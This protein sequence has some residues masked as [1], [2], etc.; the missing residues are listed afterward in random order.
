MLKKM[1]RWFSSALCVYRD[2]L[3][4]LWLVERYLLELVMTRIIPT[5]VQE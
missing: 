1:F 3:I 2:H 5:V 4:A